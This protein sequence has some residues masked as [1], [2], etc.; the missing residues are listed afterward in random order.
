MAYTK[1]ANGQ[2]KERDNQAKRGGQEKKSE[3]A[4][5]YTGLKILPFL[6]N[7]I[8]TQCFLGINY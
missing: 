8:H 2:K 4:E 5:K 7:K 6:C 3:R 1:Q